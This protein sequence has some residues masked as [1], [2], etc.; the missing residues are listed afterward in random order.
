M[1]GAQ[2][3]RLAALAVVTARRVVPPIRNRVWAAA[4][5]VVAAGPGVRADVGDYLGKPIASVQLHIDGRRVD[6]A[7]L[8]DVVETR[9]GEPLAMQDVR[10]TVA[11]L[12]T[13]GRFENLAV[14]ATA[15]ETGVALVFDLTPVH[16][17]ERITF[18]GITA[19]AAIDTGQLNTA[20]RER[21]G[22]APPA[23]RA[24]EMAGFVEEQLRNRGHLR[25]KVDPAV[26]LRRDPASAIL[27]LAVDPGM[28]TR[29]GAVEAVG[30]SGASQK[31]LLSRL[32]VSSGDPYEPEALAARIETYLAGRRSEGYYD[33]R[34]T[35]TARFSGD[36]RVVDVTFTMLDGPRTTLVFV[37]DPLSEA[38]RQELVPVQS[39]GSTSE[40]LLEDSSLR[41]E[42]YLRSQGYRDATARYSREERAGEVFITFTV[43]NGSR[44]LVARPVEVAGNGAV[45]SA[46]IEARVRL[47]PG[48]PFSQAILDRDVSAIADLYREG[49][50]ASVVVKSSVETL[51]EEDGAQG[52]IPLVV[53]IAI[54]ESVR[55]VV[56]S[57]RIEGNATVPQAVLLEG[58]GLRPGQPLFP[59]QLAIDRDAIQ[60]TYLNLGYQHAG[61]E[62]RP[63]ISA[64]ATAA[65]VVFVVS[66]GPQLFV[67]HVLI[68]GI[69][70]TSAETIE[71]EL[72]VKS[73]DP[74]GLSALVESQRRLAALGLFRR[75]R[76]TQLDHG[77]ATTRDV[78]VSVEEAP[79]SI[80]GY[81]GGVEL[82]QRI[83]E[84]QELGGT[85][86]E[87]LELTPRAFFE[88]TRRNLF[89]K[90]RSASV[91]TRVSLRPSD[92]QND[93]SGF[94]FSEY[95]V[96]GTF[97]EP[98]VFG[99]GV[100]GFLTA[101]AEQQ[102]RSSFSFWR[103][104]L[105]AEGGRA[106]TRSI[107]VSG[108]Y[109]IQRTELFD[110]KL[111]P[112]DVRLIDRAFPQ[113]LLSSFSAATVR[114]TRDDQLN[115]AAGELL[116]A[117][118]QLAARMIGS[119]VGFVKWYLTGQVF[120]RVPGAARVVLATSARV[121]L[122][123][124]F[125]REVVSAAGEV[126]VG[127]DLP[128]SERFFAGGDTTVRGFARDQLGTPET[129]DQDGFPIG[130][131][132]LTIFNV[133]LRLP[134]RGGLGVVGF[135]DSGNVF[136]LTT[137]IDLG[138][139][140]SA[141]G[142]GVRYASPVGPIRVDLGFK[143]NRRGDERLT[144]LH[145]SFGQAF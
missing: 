105:S 135:V 19:G 68:A 88:V 130:G 47:Q 107:H 121:G 21:Y 78:L 106:L 58:L 1:T 41:I 2:A 131:N 95:R 5:I 143:A 80:V 73:G 128:A 91:F 12:F 142:F 42:E 116:S 27:V 137:D 144:A 134:V 139:L 87:R 9:V 30:V 64:D 99:T 132:A 57:V 36:D 61:V 62:S 75:T 108:N 34:L 6:D 92:E 94:S 85:A 138:Q 35:V 84:S 90:N 25:A 33:A 122:A 20:L 65:D 129:I 113:V 60:L 54:T 22:P 126:D 23:A 82:G 102:I 133:E 93:T 103:R 7:R 4:L 39:E 14:H 53:R 136:A 115:P 67:D 55:T 96:L 125:P 124:G 83:H 119:E 43:K 112:G 100:D 31:T 32:G 74:L 104:A 111:N 38:R 98:R 70:R 45:P 110:E 127:K 51:P 49:G 15:L 118:A 18:T 71:R 101:T 16:L 10:E 69:S 44:Y 59:P 66:E 89:G 50:F 141:L 56:Q 123:A 77:D 109:Q 76:I 17:I 81:G 120:R 97:R 48:Q 145:V 63:G 40:D 140:R 29:V 8:F 28:R 26:Q 86:E 46:E 72:L 52:P 24:Q 114:D 117:N 37:G 79:A 13:L 11:H 3:T